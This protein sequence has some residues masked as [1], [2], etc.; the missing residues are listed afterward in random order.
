M[1]KYFQTF[2]YNGKD[3]S[4]IVCKYNGNQD[5]NKQ[6]SIPSRQTHILSPQQKC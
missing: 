5:K 1:N 2:F 6:K 3:N 4:N